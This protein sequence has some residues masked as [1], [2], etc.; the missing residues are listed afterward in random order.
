MTG[1]FLLDLEL[2]FFKSLGVIL[3][4]AGWFI[5]PAILFVLFWELRLRFIRRAF[6]KKMDFKIM[7]VKIP[8]NIFITAKAM[9]QIFAAM[10]S[11]YSFGAFKNWEKYVLGKVETF[12]SFEIE[13]SSAGVRFYIYHPARLRKLIEVAIYA[14]YP[15]AEIHDSF[16]Y[17]KSTP[18][19]LPNSEYEVWG[20]NFILNRENYYPIKTYAY[21]E[22]T[23]EEKRIDPLAHIVEVISNLKEGERIWY[24]VIIAGTGKPTGNDWQKEGEDKISEI[25]GR[26][27]EDKNKF[28]VW[29]EFNMWVANFFK[30]PFTDVNW[31]EE[32]KEEKPASKFLTPVEQ[33]IVKAINGKTAKLGFE[34]VIRIIYIDQKE[35]F[36]PLNIASILGTFQQFGASD[37][38]SFK[39]GGEITG[40]GNFLS[41][42]S[43]RYKKM[44]E[45]TKK[46]A[47]YFAYI[48]RRFG[49]TNWEKKEK[50]PVLNTEELATIYHFPSLTIET[51][52]LRR[53]DTKKGGPPKGLPIIKM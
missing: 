50:F 44:M 14:Q 21:F 30:A 29:G 49:K 52:Q 6:I 25:A 8:K 3:S 10:Y 18:I 42:I 53:L 17:A 41:K 13:G 23:E 16:D 26:K 27:K 40:V 9:E 20:T 38:N 34:T 36:T 32:K 45:F 37:I 46:R 12:A 4:Y 31:G 2:N 15:N 5:I 47:I 1:N 24:Q 43:S 39:P 48:N 19:H 7:E 51:P 22:E 11:I 35:A 28:S 33:N